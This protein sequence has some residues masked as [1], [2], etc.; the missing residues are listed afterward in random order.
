MNAMKAYIFA[1]AFLIKAGFP[2]TTRCRYS[3]LVETFK[4]I[5]VQDLNNLSDSLISSG[6]SIPDLTN[7]S[8]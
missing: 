4:Y 5:V 2:A 6:L 7:V 3:F 1:L 8:D